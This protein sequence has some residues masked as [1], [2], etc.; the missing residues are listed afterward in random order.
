M[1]GQHEI[2][3]SSIT[4]THGLLTKQIPPATQTTPSPTFPHL[5]VREAWHDD[6]VALPAPCRL[7]RL[8][9]II[10]RLLER[11]IQWAPLRARLRLHVC[12][13]EGGIE[14]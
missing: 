13:S 9:S 14:R 8:V 4:L 2:H 12:G 3:A 1:A 5:V 11:V 6:V 10:H 7:V